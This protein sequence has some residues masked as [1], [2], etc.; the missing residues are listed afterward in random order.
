LFSL[1]A[2]AVNL[3]LVA[4]SLGSRL[5][6]LILWLIFYLLNIVG[7]LGESLGS[8]LTPLILWLIFY[9]TCSTLWAAVVSHY[10]HI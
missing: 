9:C 4:G 3:G 2:I 7:S 1:A 8:R 5:T 10:Q 6:P